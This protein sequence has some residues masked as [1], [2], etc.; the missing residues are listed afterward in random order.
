MVDE[1]KG[2]T[3][4]PRITGEGAVGVYMVNRPTAAAMDFPRGNQQSNWPPR[5]A[6]PTP[7]GRRR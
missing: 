2:G 6:M 7:E 5:V 3:T 1:E 4:A